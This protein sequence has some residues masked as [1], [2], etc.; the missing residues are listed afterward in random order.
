MVDYIVN[1]YHN[2]L[3]NENIDSE[4]LLRTLIPLIDDLDIPMIIKTQLSDGTFS[5]EHLNIDIEYSKNTSEYN[6][7]VE[8]TSTL[9]AINIFIIFFIIK[10]PLIKDY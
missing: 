3:T 9:K 2:K 6:Q 4:Y 10:F 1:I 7:F 5:Y 8:K